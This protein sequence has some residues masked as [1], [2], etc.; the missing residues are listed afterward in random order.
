[1]IRVHST[2]L[3]CNSVSL[4]YSYTAGGTVLLYSYYPEVKSELEEAMNKRFLTKQRLAAKRGLTEAETN[5]PTKPLP[6]AHPVVKAAK[7]AKLATKVPVVHPVVHPL[8]QKPPAPPRTFGIPKVP[9]PPSRPL[10]PFVPEGICTP[11]PAKWLELYAASAPGQ[12]TTDAAA[13]AAAAGPMWTAASASTGP[14]M[15]PTPPKHPPPPIMHVIASLTPLNGGDRS[16]WWNKAQVLAK[17]ILENHP[18]Q[19]E[20]ANQWYDGDGDDSD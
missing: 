17:A 11:P 2:L 14:V 4:K 18:R 8:L 5:L 7:A 9:V 3:A 1:M 20:I 10:A 13:A 19:K 16:V 6:E 15:R 12:V